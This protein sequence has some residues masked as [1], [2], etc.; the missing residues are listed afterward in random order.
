SFMVFGD[1]AELAAYQSLVAAFHAKSPGVQVNLTH[2]P[3][4]A[5]YRT[6][7]A[8]D[9]AAGAPADVVL[10]NYRRYAAFATKNVLQPLGPYLAKSA[11]ISEADFYP[12]ALQ[13]FRWQGELIC[14]PQN[15]SSLVVY[16]NKDLFALAGLTVP[17]DDWTWDDFLAAAQALTRDADGDGASDVFGLG[18]EASIFRIAPFIWQNGGELVNDSVTP[19]RLALDTPEALEAIQW[20]VDLQTRHRVTPNAAEEASEDSESRFINGR[21]GMY[22]NSR[23]GVPTY[24]EI[25]A[26]DWDVA[27]LPRKQHAASILH[28][29]AY[30]LPAASE[31]KDA[32]WRFIEFANS[33]EG[34]AIVAASGRTVPSLVGVA[35]SSA[36]LD[37]A[38]KPAHSRVFLDTIALLRTVPIH[39]NWV[40]IEE[41][42]SEELER[43]FY[44]DAPVFEAVLTAI[45]RCAI[46][47]GENE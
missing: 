1:P 22:L 23:R 17:A 33:A 7:L 24:R 43:A 18:V 25:T 27:A 42:S 3:G 16:Y 32:A 2:I 30:C 19:T 11:A 37:P 6:R 40:D 46:Y 13:P 47:F 29:D 31:N 21:L 35:E 15:I 28:A 45:R 9:F 5:E 34:Q 12:Q 44:G 20:F 26:F 14:I 38:K 10:I 4:Q 36:F 39:A 8:A 41:I